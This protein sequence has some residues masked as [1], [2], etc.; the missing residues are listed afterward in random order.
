[1]AGK[2]KKWI[3]LGLVAA[4]MLTGC[5]NVQP[6]D[7]SVEYETESLTAM[8][9]ESSPMDTSQETAENS[10]EESEEESVVSANPKQVVVYFANWNLNEKP[11]AEGG[12]VASIPWDSVSYVNHAFWAVVPAD[13]S[14]Q[15]STERRNNGQEPRTEFKIVSTDP[16]NDY[17]DTAASAVDPTMERNHFAEYAVYAEKY[18][19]VNIML[20][21]GGWSRCGYFSEMAYTQEGRNSFVQSCMEVLQEYPWIDGIDIDWEYPG[22]SKDGERKPEGGDDQGCPIFGTMQE[23]DA[24]FALLLSDLRTALDEKFGAGVKKLTACASASTAWTL[25]CQDW[26][27]AEPYLDMINIMTYDLAGTWDG[28]TGHAGSVTGAKNAAVYLMMKDISAEKLCIGSPMY[29]MALQM[30][31][32]PG[33]NVVGTAI[34]SYKPTDDEID[35]EELSGYIADAVSGYTI[36]QD[37]LRYVMDE[38]FDQ[39]TVGW[40]M[41]YDKNNGAAYLYN[42]DA[43]S[44]YYKWYL[45]YEDA[46]SL[47]GKLDYIKEKGLAGIIV[48]ESSLD[49]PNHGYIRQMGDQLLGEQ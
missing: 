49:L 39:D 22:G 13:G 33:G 1:M 31:E 43:D 23:D 35:E 47:Q 9:E 27:A 6:T 48:W 28:V 7:A 14:T 4:F 8:S 38:T 36:K 32:I 29:A 45:S 19:D 3:T 41:G 20:S 40:H 34:E 11:A 24:N 12:E 21:I 2:T 5:G 46:L 10:T 16:K 37:G 17:E 26:V 15:T 30:K 25:P 18:P 44:P 42:D